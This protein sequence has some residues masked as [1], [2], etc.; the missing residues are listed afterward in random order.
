MAQIVDGNSPARLPVSALNVLGFS[1]L[2][3]PKRHGSCCQK[4]RLG[5]RMAQSAANSSH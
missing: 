3:Q 2:I 4:Y 5:W 1:P